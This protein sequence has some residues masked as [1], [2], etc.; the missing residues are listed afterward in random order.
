MRQVV[1]VEQTSEPSPALVKPAYLESE[2][3]ENSPW[4]AAWDK[5]T[6]ED[7]DPGE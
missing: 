3:D 7:L 6:P 4:A 5:F 2:L 1:R